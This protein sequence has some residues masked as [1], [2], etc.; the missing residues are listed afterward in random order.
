MVII[1]VPVDNSSVAARLR[2]CRVRMAMTAASVVSPSTP[3]LALR[4]SS[5][6]SVPSCPF[7]WLCLCS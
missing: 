1:G 7:A 4:L 2:A 3:W 5:V 6:P